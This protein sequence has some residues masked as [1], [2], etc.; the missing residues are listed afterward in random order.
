MCYGQATRVGMMLFHGVSACSDCCRL[1]VGVGYSGLIPHMTS[2]VL[3]PFLSL[4]FPPATFL[5]Q[6]S[7]CIA[8]HTVANTEPIR[9]S[10][11]EC[12]SCGITQVI[13]NTYVR[14]FFRVFPEL[15]FV[16]YWITAK[17]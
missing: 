17:T 1:S 5:E 4:F 10:S 6:L 9:V 14:F 16:L 7:C 12:L 8:Q 3:S 15:G 11:N 13:F 2:A